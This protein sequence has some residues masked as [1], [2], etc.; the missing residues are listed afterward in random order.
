VTDH[1]CRLVIGYVTRRRNSGDSFHVKLATKPKARRERSNP[2]LSCSLELPSLGST[3]AGR[4]RAA[5]S[6][7]SPSMGKDEEHQSLLGRQGKYP[8]PGAGN[9]RVK[10]RGWVVQ[11]SCRKCLSSLLWR[12]KK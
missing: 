10:W 1:T 6:T 9:T 3:W 7:K 5:R 12:R 4:W 8:L 11:E 2:E